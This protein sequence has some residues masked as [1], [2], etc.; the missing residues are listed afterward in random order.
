MSL[1]SFI[2]QLQG[3]RNLIDLSLSSD[4]TKVPSLVFA[5]S[6]S[7]LQSESPLL[8]GYFFTKLLADFS[9]EDLV[10][11]TV[12]PDPKTAIGMGYGESKWVASRILETAREVTPLRP[13]IVRIG[14]LCGNNETGS[15]NPWE[16]FPTIVRSAKAIGS[17]PQLHGV[18]V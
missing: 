7:D 14:Q 5:S 3:L 4:L 6:I 12:N 16:W 8:Q 1:K 10:P 18:S 2:P 9:G 13:V 15:W 11:A 17:L